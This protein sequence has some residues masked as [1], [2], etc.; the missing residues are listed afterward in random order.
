MV[1]STRIPSG[2]AR[3]LDVPWIRSC[4]RYTDLCY[5]YNAFWRDVLDVFDLPDPQAGD[6]RWG[7]GFEIETLLNCR[8]AAA[9]LTI[10]EIPSYASGTGR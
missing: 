3:R 10:L 6:T 5:G 9:R 8:A 1:R 4:S 7:E 2:N